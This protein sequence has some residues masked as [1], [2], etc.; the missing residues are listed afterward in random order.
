M[1]TA[2]ERAEQLFSKTEEKQRAADSRDASFFALRKQQEAANQEKTRRLRELRLAHEA[3]LPP[4]PP[5][6]PRTRRRKSD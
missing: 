3:T 1:T 5:T 2:R 4:A 6:K